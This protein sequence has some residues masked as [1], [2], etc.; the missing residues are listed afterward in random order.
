MPEKDTVCKGG[1]M[2]QFTRV[3]GKIIVLT[4]R[5][6]S[7]TAMVMPILAIG[8]QTSHMGRESIIIKISQPTREIGATICRKATAS[9]LGVR[10]PGT[11][12]CSEAARKKAGA[13]TSGLMAPSTEVLGREIAL[14]VAAHILAATDG[15]SKAGGMIPLSME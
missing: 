11:K 8:S 4:V 13:F 3:N 6:D 7:R 2:V 12:A 15:C 1:P 10:D 5:D 14:M 9:K